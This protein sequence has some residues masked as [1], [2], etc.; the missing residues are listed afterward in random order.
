MKDKLPKKTICKWDRRTL[1]EALPLLAQQVVDAKYICRKCG[2]AVKEKRLLCKPVKLSS[3]L[4][5]EDKPN[6]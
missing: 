3:L 1:E 2:R 5:P 6:S 4:P